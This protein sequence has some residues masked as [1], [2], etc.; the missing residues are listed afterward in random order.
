ML[1]KVTKD[2]VGIFIS[3][4]GTDNETII[5]NFKKMNKEN[6]ELFKAA[7]ALSRE[8]DDLNVREGFLRGVFVVYSLL[9]LQEE[10]EEVDDLWDMG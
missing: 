7:V 1:P 5:K 4:V 8:S 3:K 10:I 2:V 6:P 9:I